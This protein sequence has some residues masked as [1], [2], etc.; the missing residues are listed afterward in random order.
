MSNQIFN[1][2]NNSNQSRFGSNNNNENKRYKYDVGPISNNSFM[3]TLNPVETGIFLITATTQSINIDKKLNQLK[4]KLQAKCTT[5]VSWMYPIDDT[6]NLDVEFIIERTFNE[7]IKTQ[8]ELMNEMKQKQLQALER[9]HFS[10]LASIGI[11]APAGQVAPQI[12][13]PRP[14]LPARVVVPR[15]QGQLHDERIAINQLNRQNYDAQMLIF[16]AQQ[17]PVIGNNVNLQEVLQVHA[18]YDALPIIPGTDPNLLR[19]I[20]FPTEQAYRQEVNRLNL[21]VQIEKQQLDLK[22]LDY[23]ATAQKQIALTKSREKEFNETTQHITQWFQDNFHPVVLKQYLPMLHENKF[24]RVLYLI[25]QESKKHTNSHETT[26]AFQM[27]LSNFTYNCNLT[28]T[29]NLDY[30]E[31]LIQV[32][33]V[34]ENTARFQLLKSLQSNR[35]VGHIIPYQTVTLWK[36]MNVSYICRSKKKDS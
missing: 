27:A 1:Q 30:F 23:A 17:Q 31:E 3:T 34:N 8:D 22:D 18:A 36:E 12:L 11:A 7:I 10:Q 33:D 4:T 26:S 2:N 21:R 19:I 5:A 29:E 15:G 35:S 13:I 14:I 32:L 9:I 20:S 28:S 24:K 16:Q 25:T 6:P